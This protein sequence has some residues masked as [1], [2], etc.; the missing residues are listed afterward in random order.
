MH[1]E[2]QA[3]RVT[4]LQGYSGAGQLVDV[5]TDFA[6]VTLCRD[7]GRWDE[8]RAMSTA[9]GTM[10]TTWF[11]GSADEFVRRSMEAARAGAR[12]QHFIGAATIDLNGDKAIGETRMMLLLRASPM[13]L[14]RAGARDRP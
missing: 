13:F 4:L 12:G 5:P 3:V 7:T 10:H 14:R 2:L 9:D 11:G 1:H 6:H 8:L